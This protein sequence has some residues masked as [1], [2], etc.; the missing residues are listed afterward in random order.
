MPTRFLSDAE[1]KRLEGFPEGID[2]RDLTRHFSL[3]SDDLRFV[4]GQNGA[5]GQ[6]G[7]ALQLCSLRWLGFVPDDLTAAPAEAVAALAAA[8]DVP[9]RAIFGCSGPFG[10]ELH[11]GRS[12]VMRVQQR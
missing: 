3:A 6:L 4:R 7:I 10:G 2:R 5:P 12:M 8:L 11:R 9:A 1:I